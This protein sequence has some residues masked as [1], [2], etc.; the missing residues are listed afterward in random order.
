MVTSVKEKKSSTQG[1]PLAVS[2]NGELHGIIIMLHFP[3]SNMKLKNVKY[4]LY[5]LH[6]NG[7]GIKRPEKICSRYF[8]SK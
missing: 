3:I 4:K 2:L 8:E 6:L 5:T 1:Q 7:N